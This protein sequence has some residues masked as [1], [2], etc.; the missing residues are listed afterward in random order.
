MARSKCLLV[1]SLHA[2]Q[3][4]SLLIYSMA[5]ACF[6][7]AHNCYRITTSCW[8]KSGCKSTVIHCHCMQVM[9]HTKTICVL[10]GGALLFHELITVR[11]A[12]GM[13]LAVLGMV[14]YGYFTHREKLAATPEKTAANSPE[15]GEKGKGGD[16][17]TAV[18]LQNQPPSRADSNGVDGP[19]AG[20]LSYFYPVSY[21]F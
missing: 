17:E 18:L 15:K 1:V 8:A 5:R 4:I 21:R 20:T 11:I 9:G 16:G 7:M 12:T 6:H 2:I 13:S 19:E 3:K 10:I 14:G